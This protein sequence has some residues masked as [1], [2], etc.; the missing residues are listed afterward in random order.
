MQA[1]HP[2]TDA[3]APIQVASVQ[4]L[5]RRH[6]PYT[7]VVIVDEAHIRS[8][9]ID[10][11]M[12]ERPEAVFIGLSATPWRRGMGRQW[13]DLVVAATTPEL[14]PD[15]YLSAFR[16][17]AAA[18]PDL[19]GVRPAAGDYPAGALAARMGGGP[20]GD[21]GVTTWTEK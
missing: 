4:T 1:N 7:N 3:L 17:F 9:V 18:P 11:L 2:R 15:G 14:I 16:V 10:R 19:A 21:H 20:L 5:A 12:A 13:Q 8:E 6:V